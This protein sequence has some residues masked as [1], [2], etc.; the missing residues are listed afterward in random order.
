MI[1][2]I[3]VVGASL[4][5]AQDTDI[6]VLMISVDGMMPASYTSTTAHVP[7]LRALKAEGAFAE[8]VVGVLPSVTYPSHTTLITGVLPAVHGILDNRMFD[9][10]GRSNNANYW[11]ASGIHVP[12]ILGAARSRGLRTAAIAWPVTVGMEVD[13]HVPEFWRVTYGTDHPESLDLL[14][15][16]STPHLIDAIEIARR[17]PLPARQSDADRLDM[18]QFILRTYQPQLLLVHFTDLDSIE[19]TKGP[20]SPPALETLEQIDGYIGALRRTVDDSGLRDRTYIVVVS[21][22][23]FMPVQTMLQPNTILK[24]EGLLKTDERG[25]VLEYEAYFHSCGGSGFVFLKDPAN[26]ALVQRVRGLMDKLRADPANGIQTIWTHEQIVGAGA[27]PNAVVGIDMK[28]GFYTGGASD[29]LLVDVHM[30]DGREMGGGH[31]F[32]PNRPELHASLVVSGPTIKGLGSLGVVRMTQIAPTVA[33]WLGV[34]LS[35]LADRPLDKLV[36]AAGSKE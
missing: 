36:S 25:R 7:A 29:R 24:R 10:E 11:Y 12:T 32:D 9:P 28:S 13:Y 34:G 22:H 8:G 18:A 20:G 15:A 23:G 21:D 4:V 5:L 6:H 31:G 35:P 17:T 14:R 19:H 3:L 33:R 30:N 2:P 16:V 1:L 27:F 26:Q